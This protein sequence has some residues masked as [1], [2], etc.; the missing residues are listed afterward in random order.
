MRGP[1]DAGAS[2]CHESRTASTA[3]LRAR[4]QAH[5]REHRSTVSLK[6]CSSHPRAN[7]YDDSG[8]PTSPSSAARRG[9]PRT[10][11]HS[12]ADPPRTATD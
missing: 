5:R 2:R 8:K 4:L 7:L 1:G 6:P 12:L 9:R 10:A 3:Q 11:R